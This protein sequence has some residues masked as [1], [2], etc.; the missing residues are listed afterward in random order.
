MIT[1]VNN[2]LVG[3][4]AGNAT[5]VDSATAGQFVVETIDGTDKVRIG[6]ATKKTYNDRQGVSHPIIKWAAPI[7]KDDVR[8]IALSQYVETLEYNA[9]ED[10]VTIDLTGAELNSLKGKRIVVRL[11]FKD[12]PTRFRKWSESY[13]YLVQNKDTLATIAE[14]IANDINKQAKRARVEATANEGVITLVAMKYTDD[15]SKDSI[16]PAA[17]VRF[18]AT[19]WYTDPK[20]PGFSSKNKYFVAGAV[21]SKTP[22]REY[23]ATWKLVRDM[24]AQAMGYEGI[25][26]RGECTWPIIKPEMAVTE[27]GEYDCLTIMFENNYRTADDLQR[28]TKQMI[29]IYGLVGV[30]GKSEKYNDDLENLKKEIEK[31]LG[32]STSASEDPQD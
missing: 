16:S 24:E 6:I 12:L 23:T 30:N 17:K 2:A 11:T 31:A 26:N 4:G 32:I 14:H 13:E 18:S 29:N 28:K 3:V 1:Y 9:D 20:A 22:G 8:S 25:L 27:D 19:M 15:G 7:Q 10:T 5:S 21:I